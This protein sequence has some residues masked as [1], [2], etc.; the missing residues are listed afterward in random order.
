MPGFIADPVHVHRVRVGF[1]DC[2]PA[3]IVYFPRFFHF[4]HEAMESWFDD[5]LGLPYADMIHVRK[6]GFPAVHTEADFRSPVAMGREIAVE[7][8]VVQ[9][10]RSSIRF[11]YTVRLVGEPA[12]DVRL[13]GA[14]VSVVM[15]LDPQRPTFRRAVPLPD[16]LRDRI[17]P[18]VAPAA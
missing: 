16:D 13:I 1:G 14:T 2:D 17:A 15:D 3:G 18:L 9:L 11:A 10:G 12:D 4:F 5:V 6:L 7:Q 8:R